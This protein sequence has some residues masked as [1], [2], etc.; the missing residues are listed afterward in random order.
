[1]TQ[2][3]AE[4]FICQSCPR[5][6]PAAWCAGCDRNCGTKVEPF[7]FVDARLTGPADII[8]VS[9]APVIG[10]GHPIMQTHI[11][12]ADDAGKIITK[13]V[14]LARA[15]SPQYAKL[16]V[17][18][19]YVVL[20][21]G[22]DPSKKTQDRCAGFLQGGLMLSKEPVI[23]AMGLGAVKALGI[24]A[25]KLGE[26]Q[27]RVL[28]GV[29]L[30]GRT[31]TVV[32]TL[33]SKQLVSMPGMY[34]NFVNDIARAFVLTENTEELQ[35]PLAEL[36][37]DYVFPKNL[38]E[39]EEICERIINYGGKGKPPEQWIISAD[40]ETNTK[41][42]HL[43]KLKLLAVS[44]AWDI[45]K[46][47]AIPLFHKDCPYDP[48]AA[49]VFV[50][51]VLESRKPKTF[52]NGKFDTK[53]FSRYGWT[54]NNWM[55]DSM[56]AE[57]ALSEDKKGQYGL[58]PLT[59]V[60]YPQFAGYAD[61]L[62]ELLSKEEGD[63][64]LGT[65]QQQHEDEEKEKVRK[66]REQLELA[67]LKPVKKKLAKKK[68]DGGFE[69]IPLDMLLSYA[70][71]DTDITRRL[72]IGQTARM[73]EEE[74]RLALKKRVAQT[75]RTRI[76]P[77]PQ[78]YTEPNPTREI[79][80]IRT[81][82]VAKVLATMELGGVRVNR[83]R[84]NTLKN[85]LG[86]VIDDAEKE[87]RV[88]S[89][90]DEVNLNSSQ[91]VA[92]L[93][94]NRGFIHPKTGDLTRYPPVTLTA[95]GQAQ[96]TEKVLRYLVA[97]FE[98]PFS[99]QKLVYSKAHKAKNTFLENVDTLSEEDC[100]IHSNFNQH[101]TGT[102][103]LSSNDINLQ[104]IPKQ[105]AG[106]YIKEIFVTDD[107]DEFVFVN[108]DAKGAE[109]RILTA[110]SRDKA[111]I[112]A[113]N[114]GQDT[115]C[116]IA[117][118]IIEVVRMSSG[119]AKLLKEMGL[120]D[121]RPLTYE[122]FANRDD[123]AKTDK[124]Y[125]TMLHKFRD[126]VK[127]VVFGI[128]YGAGAAKIAETIGISKE[129]AQLIIDMLFQMFPSIPQYMAQTRWELKTF[130]MV[131][132][133]FGHRRRFDV[134]GAAKFLQSRAERQGVNFKIQSTSSDI[135]MDCLRR[136]EQPLMR[137][138]GGR[139]LLTVHDSIGFQFR[140]KLLGQ[141]EDFLAEHLQRQTAKEFPWLPVAFKWDFEV[142]PSYGELSPLKRYLDKHPL[143][144]NL[145][146]M[147][148]AYTEEEIRTELADVAS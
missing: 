17:A 86:K 122:D 33:S 64:L 125:Y 113:L 111:L 87:L 20:C 84:L 43:K 130:N 62:H 25:S 104:N 142:G 148:Q 24:K 96:T 140:K 131:E 28:R 127:R 100:C 53:V 72:S 51:R 147:K 132:T 107:N 5:P 59:N 68:E 74:E 119:A 63:S 136:I 3:S 10:R 4:A 9:E 80:K 60:F 31:Y 112:Q 97:K 133:F 121:A 116:F 146:I 73:R 109:V 41:F 40:C 77:V 13:T 8:I 101:G 22:A 81:V 98:C 46:A 7:H 115:H 26:V 129:Q 143:K 69:K 120:D 34:E 50:R 139:L 12:Y 94:F 6:K 88:M 83:D 55:W 102:Y 30:N 27:H 92:N 54:V 49:A 58:K 91:H 82:P 57:H 71:I 110:Y 79:V 134:K 99:A 126:A 117:S 103:R 93:L 47:A 37:K 114:D 42:P 61:K 65:I 16:K 18:K 89:G 35:M 11:P 52:H 14:D 36:T 70:A 56:L 1:M 145:D 44:F 39:V 138:M 38:A 23:V 19:T 78:L 118:K 95:K 105:L 66:E 45:A 21:S 32:V 90:S 144:E 2:T 137:D 76:Y 106:V 67:G 108:A 85:D 48:E 75:D 141:L 123:I 128:L 124:A 135:V 29:V 15:R